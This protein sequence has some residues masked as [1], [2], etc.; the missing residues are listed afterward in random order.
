MLDRFAAVAQRR[1]WA[2]G[3]QPG[4]ILLRF[5]AVGLNLQCPAELCKPLVKAALAGQ[6]DP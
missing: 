1:Q 2:G 5:E 3:P 6:R 4:Q